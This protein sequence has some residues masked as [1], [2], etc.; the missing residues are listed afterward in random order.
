MKQFVFVLGLAV[1]LTI[2]FTAPAV[3]AQ[4]NEIQTNGKVCSNPSSPCGKGFEDNALSFKLPPKL[5]WQRN[6]YSA[7]FYAIVLKSRAAVNDDHVDGD[8]CTRGYFSEEERERVQKMFP[9]N[10][11][12]ASR[13]GCYLPTVW[14]TGVNSSYEFIAIYAGS[15]KAEAA[16]LLKQIK[17]KEEFSSANIRQMKVVYGYGD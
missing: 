13:N 14:Y 16:R 8:N 2:I 6:Y 3:K 17:A 12:F 11:V 15:T 1:T 9:V 5:T 7:S 4:S 10:K